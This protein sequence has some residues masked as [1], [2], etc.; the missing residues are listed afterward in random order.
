MGKEPQP[1]ITA[2]VEQFLRRYTDSFLVRLLL[3]VTVPTYQEFLVCV[4]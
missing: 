4:W 2:C 1:Q 3:F